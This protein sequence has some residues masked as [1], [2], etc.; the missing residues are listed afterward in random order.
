MFCLLYKK[1]ST[2]KGK[3]WLTIVINSF[4]K[5]KIT[6]DKGL[7]IYASKPE[8][9]KSHHHST[10]WQKNYQMHPVPLKPV[11]NR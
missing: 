1:V 8:D 4:L 9:N 5:E 2:L 11:L 10:K 6:F 3:Y 7:A